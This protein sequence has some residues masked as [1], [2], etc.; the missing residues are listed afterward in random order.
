MP[1]QTTPCDC[2][3]RS[4]PHRFDMKCQMRRDDNEFLQSC[5]IGGLGYRGF[6]P[7]AEAARDVDRDEA[8]AMNAMN[9]RPS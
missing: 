2:P 6:G 7:S 5:A 9:A 4:F 8:A 3:L 1:V